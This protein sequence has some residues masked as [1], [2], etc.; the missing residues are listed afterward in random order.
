MKKR[1]YFYIDE[2]GVLNNLD[3]GR[4]FILT[5]YITDT[6]NIIKEKLE[7]LKSKIEDKPYLAGELAKFREEGFH[8]SPNHFDIRALYYELLPTLNIRIYSVVVDKLS[9]EYRILIEKYPND[10]DGYIVIMR[11][12]LYNRILSDKNE[13]LYFVFEEYGSKQSTYKT[14]LEN[15]FSEIKGKIALQLG[16]NNVN[17]TVEVHSKDDILL[18]VVDYVN[19][20]LFQILNGEKKEK[21]MQANFNL[22]EPK[23]ASLCVWHNSIFYSSKKRINFDEIKRS[24]SK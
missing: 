20:V 9:N 5:C 24:E 4:F 22:I 23:I 13:D 14:A 21:R 7:S 16:I 10:P 15:M 3:K 18:S 2:S 1:V 6:P 8:A 12:L 11:R 17:Y 19:Y